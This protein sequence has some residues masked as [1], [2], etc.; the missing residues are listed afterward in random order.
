MDLNNTNLGGFVVSNDFYSLSS[1]I[2][3]QYESHIVFD[4]STDEII[5]NNHSFGFSK[6]AKKEL[7]DDELVIT[8]EFIVLNTSIDDTNLRL[9]DLIN[10]V[11]EI[12]TMV[13]QKVLDL[14]TMVYNTILDI[15]THQYNTE[16]VLIH[17]LEYAD[18]SINLL[19]DEI[20]DIST[21]IN[22]DLD[23][24]ETVLIHYLEYID[25]S[26]YLLESANVLLNNNMSSLN[27]S[28]IDILNRLQILENA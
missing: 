4:I 10:T 26:I 16:N 28:I 7:K 15:S 8:Q 14:S 24:F 25:T 9:N 13:D 5:V 19:F 18:T 2:Q 1:E 23:D 6:R 3:S 20:T 27:A 12:P 11:D 22:K 17:Y 21:N